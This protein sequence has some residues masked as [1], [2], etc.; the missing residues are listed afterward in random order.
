MSKGRKKINHFVS[1]IIAKGPKSEKEKGEFDI[2][3]Q[4]FYNLP[5]TP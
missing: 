3:A 4:Q 1:K 2:L 5:R